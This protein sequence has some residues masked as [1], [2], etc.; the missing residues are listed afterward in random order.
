MENLPVKVKNNS[1]SQSSSGVITSMEAPKRIGLTILF[2]VFGVFG[3]WSATAPLN[4]AA[5]ATGT[6]N[7]RSYSQVVQHLEGGIISDILAGEGEYVEAGETILVLDDTQP[8][9]Q[10][11]IV[12]S[13]YVALKAREARL[14]S[15]R[16]GD[17]EMRTPADLDT[18]A[19]QVQEELQ[20]QRE[21]F[22]AR[23]N[24][25]LGEI[26]VLEQRIQQ[27]NSRLDGLRGL[28]QSN[29]VLAQSFDEELSDIRELLSQ[30]FSDKNR[31]RQIERSKAQLDGEVAELTAT[32][33]S[34]EM[35]IGEARLQIIQIDREFINEVVNTLG[36]TQTNL[37]DLTE[38]RN[39]LQDVVSRTVVRAPASGIVNGMQFHTVGGVIG[40]GTEIARIIPQSAELIIEARVSPVDIDRVAAGQ[41]A[42]VRFAAFGSS[43]PTIEGEVLSISADAFTDQNTGMSY[44]RARV[45]VTADG[46]ESLG[47][48]AL[49]PGM[50]AEVFINTGAR[51]FLQY[52][53]KPFSNAIARSFNE[54]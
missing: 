2:L 47:D 40:P 46:T 34:T 53:F 19:S 20:A 12:N 25:R 13:Q 8:L 24:S 30:G 16:D 49:I 37:K 7:V 11:E 43:V 51:T 45:E 54:D 21:I 35:Q 18:T 52:L 15:E 28:K 48:L 10:L 33:A 29:S 22:T 36:E 17:A 9:A 39:A 32:I 44:Y 3:I 50:P 38:R 41:I 31:L 26:E 27:L 4:S 1:P 5:V 14:L 42:T 23:R 6:V